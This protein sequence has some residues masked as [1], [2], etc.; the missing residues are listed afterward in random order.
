MPLSLA[1]DNHLFIVT[2]DLFVL[3]RVLYKWNHMVCVY[4]YIYFYFF[5]FCWLT[6]L[7]KIIL[8]FIH[9]VMCLLIVH[10]SILLSIPLYSYITIWLSTNLLVDISDVSNLELWQIKLLWTFQYKSLCGHMLLSLEYILK[11][12]MAESC[13]RYVFN[14]INNCQTVFQSG[15]TILLSYQQW[16]SVPI[17]P[18]PCQNLVWSGLLILSTQ[19]DE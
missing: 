15:F 7:G 1:P 4:I 3:F 17:A 9:I 19:T 5:S 14:F 8:G 11:S 2:T 10:P 13:G 6:S 12:E 16:M 18:Q